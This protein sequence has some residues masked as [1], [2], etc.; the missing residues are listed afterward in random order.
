M[1]Q[2]LKVNFVFGIIA[3]VIIGLIIIHA[4]PKQTPSS[5]ITQKSSSTIS[6]NDFISHNKADSCWIRINGNVYDVTAYL[7]RHPGGPDMILPY[8][9]GTDATE[10]FATKG[11]RGRSHSQA[12]N[13]LHTSMLVG[14]LAH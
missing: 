2:E 13:D 9:G 4:T 11:G 12:A 8:C 5:V 3:L 14:T 10:A 1:K 7:N 6:M